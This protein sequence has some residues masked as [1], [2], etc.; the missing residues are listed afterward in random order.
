VFQSVPYIL[1]KQ[2]DKTSLNKNALEQWMFSLSREE[3]GGFREFNIEYKRND[4]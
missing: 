1:V 3:V 4:L 2:Q